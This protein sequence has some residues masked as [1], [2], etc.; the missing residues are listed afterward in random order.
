MSLGYLFTAYLI[1]LGSI[2]HI[3]LVYLAATVVFDGLFDFI[4]A[5]W[6]SRK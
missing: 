5:L 3:V 2:A 1:V 6:R 4:A